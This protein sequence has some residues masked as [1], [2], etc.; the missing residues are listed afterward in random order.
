MTTTALVVPDQQSLEEFK[1]GILASFEYEFAEAQENYTEVRV[2]G[3]DNMNRL[4]RAHARMIRA[5]RKVQAVRQGYLPVPRLPVTHLWND[6]LEEMPEVVRDRIIQA[7]NIGTFER[8]M[9][10]EPERPQGRH[11]W[12]H[13]RRTD[14]IVVGII[15]WG[16]ETE[17]HFF[18]AWWR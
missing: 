13:A 18:I 11:R 1:A 3:G 8:V 10:M 5:E 17:E 9:I 15:G 14:P 12:E 16:T 2:A 7:M 4:A 6:R